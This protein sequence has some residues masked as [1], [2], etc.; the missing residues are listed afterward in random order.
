MT[1]TELPRRLRDA[2]PTVA[3][4]TRRPERAASL[5]AEPNLGLGRGLAAMRHPNDRRCW[6]GQIG[7]NR[8]RHDGCKVGC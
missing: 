1:L 4:T 8:S 3:R 5:A 2:V 7:R 6:L